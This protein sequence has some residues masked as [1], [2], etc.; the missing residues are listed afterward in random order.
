MNMYVQQAELEETLKYVM[1]LNPIEAHEIV[2]RTIAYMYDSSWSEFG[3]D[4]EVIESIV[5]DVIDISAEQ[6]HR[7]ALL[8]V[9]EFYC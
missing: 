9:K 6:R 3:L 8:L 1:P 4:L 5:Y 7:A 2:E